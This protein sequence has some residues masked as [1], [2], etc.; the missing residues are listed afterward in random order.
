MNALLKR[1]FSPTA[2][3]R[4]KEGEAPL[5]NDLSLYQRTLQVAWPS[6]LEGVLVSLVSS[7]DSMM[8][9]TIGPEAITA[10][11]ITNQPIHRSD[12]NNTPVF[13]LLHNARKSPSHLKYRSLIGRNGKIPFLISHLHYAFVF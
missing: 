1:I 3:L 12:I 5:P 9:G 4:V 13:V 2:R 11:G 10:V 6:A 8:V 7:F